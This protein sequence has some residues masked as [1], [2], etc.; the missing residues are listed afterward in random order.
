MV[1]P[2]RGRRPLLQQTLDSVGAQ[3]LTDWEAVVVGDGSPDD[4][5]TWLAAAA[6]GDPRI[7]PIA[8]VGTGGANAARNGGLAAARG[9]YVLFLDS[10]DLLEPDCLR[11]RLRRLDARPDLDFTVHA[12]R[13]FADRPND[14]DR[15]WNT[16][17]DEDDFD[18]Y[19]LLDGP[20]QTAGA[21][22]RRTSLG[23]VGPWDPGLLSLQ[24]LDFHLRALAAGLR[25]EKVNAWD[26]HY[27]LPHGRPSIT[28]DHR[29]PPHFRSHVR[30]ARRLLG[31]PDVVLD[32]TP[33]RRDRLGGFCFLVASRCA[34]GGHAADG[35]RLWASARRRGVVRGRRFT[36]GFLML[37]SQAQPAI[38]TRLRRVL[39][40]RWPQS[41]RAEFRQTFLNAP[42]PPQAMDGTGMS[43]VAVKSDA[44]GVR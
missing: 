8:L 7:R 42:L 16:L 14:T 1:I 41:W 31:L 10:D 18:R 30:I 32:A 38:L 4:T 44:A 24:D 19:L 9:R 2:T 34:A 29:S 6:V 15:A 21:L 5:A 3:T 39:F 23:R 28:R 13:C 40:D 12:M 27:R 33:H 22:W 37:A 36:E 35:V 11:L 26:C 25:Y 20:W 43:L 17:T